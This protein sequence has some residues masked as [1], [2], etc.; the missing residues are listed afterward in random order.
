MNL[1]ITPENE[2]FMML[3]F[4]QNGGTLDNMPEDLK[5]T[6]TIWMRAD[7][8]LRKRPWY[9]N[10][11]IANQLIAD[12][13]EYNLALQTAKKHVT[14]AKKY[15]DFVETDS[16]ATHRRILVEKAYKQIAIL[17][18]LQISQPLKAHYISKEID[19]WCNRIAQLTKLYNEE[20][21]DEE[22]IRDITIILDVNSM[23]FPDIKHVSQKELYKMI[24]DVTEYTDITPSEKQKIIHKDVE[25]NII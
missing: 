9:S 5:R 8:I 20:E 11:T 6:R 10:E 25:G 15:F 21:K 24:Q 3:Q 12:L 22:E 18:A 4:F 1:K 14:S 7:E 16:P 23:N 17:E 2:Y 19:N 13:P